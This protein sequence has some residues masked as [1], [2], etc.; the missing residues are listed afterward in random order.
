MFKN[1]TIGRYY[2]TD[3][4]IHRLDPRTKLF[5]TMMFLITVF[6]SESLGGFILISAGLLTMVLL[7]GVPVKL[8]V[9]GVKSIMFLLVLSVI[10]TILFTKGNNIFAWGIFSISYEGLRQSL[11]IIVRLTYLVIG[12]SVLTLTTK[13]N[14]LTDG[15]E[16]AFRLLNKIKIPVH[17]IAMMMG[18]AIRFI[19][20][21][22]E[23]ADKIMKAQMVRG[24][25]FNEGGIIKKAKGIIPLIIPLIVSAINRALELATAMETRCYRGGEGR[26]KMK[27]LQYRKMDYVMYIFCLL[28][29]I[30]V[31]CV[32]LTL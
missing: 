18:I 8:Y 9:K 7:S 1:I 12:S 30:A 6:I 15:I 10:F 29:I 22:A 32:R 5:I 11:V 19:P 24:A 2:Q 3:S 21:L 17:D 27:P 14:D 31:V 25:D 4:L 13:T 20:I 16:R 26:T 23:E 28:Y